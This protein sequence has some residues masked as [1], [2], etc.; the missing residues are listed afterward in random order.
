MNALRRAEIDEALPGLLDA[1][2]TADRTSP[3]PA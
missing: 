1:I 2:V 3:K